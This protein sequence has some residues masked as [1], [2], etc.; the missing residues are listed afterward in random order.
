MKNHLR[1]LQKHLP[2]PP[3]RAESALLYTMAALL[4]FLPSA[5]SQNSTSPAGNFVPV[6]PPTAPAIQTRIVPVQLKTNA[7]AAP[8]QSTQAPEAVTP[9]LYSIGSPTNEEQ[10][11]LEYI[12]RA[13]ANPPAEGVRL[14]DTTD[15]EVLSAYSYFGV[16]LS[17]MASRFR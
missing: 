7:L 9:Q 4:C 8:S 14:E 15:S 16:N 12:N 17:L 10:L 6:A 5:W 13:R 2:A 11:Y 3:L 1:S